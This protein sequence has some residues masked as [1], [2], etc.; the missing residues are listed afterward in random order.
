MLARFREPVSGFT[1]LAG[2]VLALIGMIWLLWSS[3][4]D[5]WRMVISS[6]YGLSM[7]AT[8]VASTVMHLYSGN[9]RVL[10]V[11][12]RLDHAAIY[13]MIAGTFTPVSYVFLDGLYFGIIMA[14][15]WTMAIGGAI[16][17][18]FFWKRDTIW[19]LLYYLLMGW[20]G[21]AVVPGALPMLDWVTFLLVLGGG[22]MY[23]FGA[24]IYGIKRPNLN[25]WWGYH[26]I[27]HLFVLAGCALHFAAVAYLFHLIA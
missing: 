19:S 9:H 10:T 20:M 6:I 16:W 14:I 21:A 17:K 26:E 3:Y 4:P 27:W 24:V 13:L 12:V 5:G 23:T 18:L 15:I 25:R 8:F 22:L 7:V 2:A 11:L 1:H